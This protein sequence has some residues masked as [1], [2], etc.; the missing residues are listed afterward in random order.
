MKKLDVGKL[1][2]RTEVLPMKLVSSLESFEVSNQDPDPESEW[3]QLKT[4]LQETTA[5]VAGFA[6]RENNDWFDENDAEIQ[7]LLQNKRSRPGK[8]LACPDDQA[9]R[10]PTDQH[11]A[12]ST[13]SWEK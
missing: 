4:I 9:T 11:V 13:R 12:P 2:L 7:D 8:P 5:G 3:Q 10:A 6:S 1:Y